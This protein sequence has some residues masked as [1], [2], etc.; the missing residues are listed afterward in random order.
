MILDSGFWILDSGFWILDSGFWTL[1]PGYWSLRK[2]NQKP[3]SGNQQRLL[4]IKKIKYN[5]K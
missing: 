2:F 5:L 3:V 4:K 1:V